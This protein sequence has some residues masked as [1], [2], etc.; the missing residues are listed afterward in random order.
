MFDAPMDQSELSNPPSPEPEPETTAAG[1]P[2]RKKRL[3]WKLLQLL[4]EPPAAGPEC[5]EED[6][7]AT[8]PPAPMAFVWEGIRT[9]LNAFGL[10]R[11]YP[12]IPT[13]NPDDALSL[14]DLSDAS[15]PSAT[16]STAAPAPPP[17]QAV[18]PLPSDVSVND[19]YLPFANF[20]IWSLMNWMWNGSAAKSLGEITKLVDII[21]SPEFKKEDLEDFD[22]KRETEKFD[23]FLQ[24]V[25]D[26]EFAVRD[27]WN[28]IAVDIQVPDGKPHASED[29]IPVFSVPGLYLRKLTE[30]IRGGLQ[31]PAAKCF[32][33]TP[34]REFHQ[35]S[36]DLEPARVFDE[37]YSSDAMIDAHIELQQQ[38]PEPGCDLERVVAALMFWSDS[39]HLANFG[40]ASLWPIYL[41]FGNQSKWLRGKPRTN[42]CHHLAYIPKVIL[43]FLW[44][45]II[46]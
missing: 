17:L 22:I 15:L 42:T 23:K 40:N 27:G 32:H 5:M 41:Y 25:G 14:A 28:E 7:D 39:T 24:N 18:V 45:N 37:I 46:S 2:V 38:R 1:R 31:D 8:P 35:P 44:L 6:A 12:T 36:P 16:S 13:H 21:K 34:F 9:A 4:P 20:S 11:E 3:T 33:Y 10:Y 43:G 26:D 19:H 29:D 30:V